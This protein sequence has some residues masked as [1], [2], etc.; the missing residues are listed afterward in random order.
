M[1]LNNKWWLQTSS[2]QERTVVYS[3]SI[4]HCEEK[5]CFS[6]IE[7]NKNTLFLLQIQ[8]H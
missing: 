2:I 7:K 6:E 1:A 4:Q 8:G 5:M 3:V